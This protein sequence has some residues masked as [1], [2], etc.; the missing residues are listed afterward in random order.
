M[1][2]C[3]GLQATSSGG[4]YD[5]PHQPSVLHQHLKKQ[6]VGAGKAATLR[7]DIARLSSTQHAV[8]T[9]THNCVKTEQG[10]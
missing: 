4:G 7:A 5:Q 1:E 10:S 9:R 3:V 2:V 8:S 6:E